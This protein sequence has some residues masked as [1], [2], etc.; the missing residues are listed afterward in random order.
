MKFK[1][2]CRSNVFKLNIKFQ[3]TSVNTI[4]GLFIVYHQYL[5]TKIYSCIKV[6]ETFSYT[7]CDRI[8]NIL[9]A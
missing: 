5:V 7:I 8:K 6:E 1:K 3:D 9:L 4:H 2:K